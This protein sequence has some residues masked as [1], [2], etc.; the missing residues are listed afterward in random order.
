M[1]AA[2]SAWWY[3]QHGADGLTVAGTDGAD[4]FVGGEEAD[5]ISGLAGAD[6]LHGGDGDDLLIG[7][8]GDDWLLGGGGYDIYRYD[9]GDG[10]DILIDSDRLGHL[11][12]NG[13]QLTDAVR[14]LSRDGRPLWYNRELDVFLRFESGQ[15][16][17]PSGPVGTLIITGNGLGGPG[18]SI[19][20]RNFQMAVD[21]QGSLGISFSAA[22]QVAIIAGPQTVNPF[23]GADYV[24]QTDSAAL[25]EGSSAQLTLAVSDVADHARIIQLTASTDGVLSFVRDGVPVAL[26]TT[27]VGIEL[28]AGQM[29]LVLSVKVTGE[30]GAAVDTVLTA[31]LAGIGGDGG[32]VSTHALSLSFQGSVE[33]ATTNHVVGDGGSVIG[34][35][36]NDLIEAMV[37]EQGAAAR[38][39]NGS[40]GDDVIFALAEDDEQTLIDAGEL[41]ASVQQG[42]TY[43]AQIE[44]GNGNDRI[45]G[46]NGNDYVYAGA[47]ADLIVGGGGDDYILGDDALTT[48]EKARAGGDDDLIYGGAGND[49][50]F[51][52]RGDDVL[53]GG[54][55]DDRLRGGLGSDALFGGDGN[56]DLSGDSGETIWGQPSLAEVFLLHGDDFLD[57]G[58][59]DDLLSGGGGNDA[60]FGGD[61]NDVI[62]GG[63]REGPRLDPVTWN[64]FEMPSA[65]WDAQYP[66]DDDYLD[67]EGGDDWLYGGVGNDLLLGGE[68]ADVLYGD[69]P[70]A[71]LDHQGDDTLYGEDGDD[72][73]YGFGG[74]DLLD[75]GADDDRLYGGD[76]DDTLQGQGGND[77]LEGG[78][79]RDTLFGGDGNDQLI[80][81]TAAP[82]GPL[83]GAAGDA[84]VLDGGAGN[85]LLRGLGGDDRLLGG[86]GDDE[87][88]G[89]GGDDRLYGG[90]GNDLLYGDSPNLAAQHHGDDLL[91][92][93][94]GNDTLHGGG[95]N[96]ILQGGN[97]HDVLYGGA[98]DDR[99][100]GGD[101]ND[102][103]FGDDADGEEAG[104]DWLD[105]GDGD[106]HLYGGRGDDRLEGGAGNDVYHFAAGDGHDVVMEEAGTDTFVFGEGLSPA[107][108]QLSA[109]AIEFTK[110]DVRIDVATLFDPLTGTSAIEHFVFASEG[111]SLTFAELLA[112]KGL[113]IDAQGL[114]VGTPVNDNLRGGAGADFI[115]GGAGD[116]WLAGGAGNDLLFGGEGNDTYLFTEG[117]GVDLIQDGDGDNTIHLADG[118]AFQELS[119]TQE[120]GDVHIVRGADRMIIRDWDGNDTRQWSITWAG[121]L[122]DLFEHFNNGIPTVVD[123]AAYTS[124]DSFAA[125]SG[126]VLANDSDP[127]GEPL[128]V[129]NPGTYTGQYGTLQL[130]AD[131]AWQYTRNTAISLQ[132]LTTGES[133]TDSFT[134]TVSDGARSY[135]HKVS[136]VLDII[137]EGANDG[138]MKL[139]P[140]AQFAQQFRSMLPPVL[141]EERVYSVMLSAPPFFFDAEDGYLLAMTVT[142]ADG[143]TTPDWIHIE[144]P[145]EVQEIIQDNHGVQ[146]IPVVAYIMPDDSAVGTN[147]LR[148]YAMD[149]DGIRV[150]YSFTLNVINVNDWPIAHADTLHLQE[151]G[152]ASI[153]FQA[154]LANDTDEDIGDTLTVVS[155][156]PQS[157]QGM[158]LTVD[159][160][161]VTY[162]PAGA[163][164]FLAEGQ[165]AT[166]TFTY[167]ISDRSG[168][169][170]TGVVTVTITGQ[171]D[172]PVV[173][174]PQQAITVDDE[175]AFSFAFS[176]DVFADVDQGDVLDYT[177]TLTDGQPLPDWLS[178]DPVTLTISG[179]THKALAGSLSLLFTA[180]D[181]AGAS[182]SVDVALDVT[183]L[184]D[185]PTPAPDQF[186]VSEDAGAVTV[187]AA[188]LLAN[189]SDPDGDPL[190]VLAVDGLS[191][192]GA[193]VTLADG[194]VTWTAGRS[195]DYLAEGETVTDSFHYRV[196]DPAGRTA[197]AVVEVLVVGANDAPV[198]Q[199]DTIV[200]GEDAASVS[201]DATQLLGNDVD[202]DASD[203]LEISGMDPVSALGVTV[204]WS[205]G[206]ARYDGQGHFEYLGAGETVTDTFTYVVSDRAGSTASATVT[207]E[208]VGANDAPVVAAVLADRETD[209][210]EPFLFIVPAD[211]FT[212]VDA[213]DVLSL[214]AS[215]A[216]GSALPGWL[217]FDADSGTFS[218]VPPVG[219]GTLALR[220][221][222]TDLAGLSA[223]STFSLTVRD[224]LVLVGTDGQ[225]T[226]IGAGGDDILD[227]GAGVDVLIGGDGNDTYIVDAYA[228]AE[229]ADTGAGMWPGSAGSLTPADLRNPGA[230]LKNPGLGTPA[231]FVE[232]ETVV[233]TGDNGTDRVYASV[234]CALPDHV[235]ELVL[236]GDQAINGNGNALDNYLEGN[237]AAN[238]LYGNE[239]VD[240]LMGMGGNDLLVDSAGNGVLAGG[241]GSDLLLGNADRQL[242]AGGSGDD[243]ISTGGGIDVAL[244]N[245]G[246]GVDQVV[247]DA[248]SLT[249]S[250]GG[251]ISYQD[252]SL[253]RS[254]R[255]LVLG[256]GDGESVSLENWFG[257]D[258]LRPQVTLQVITAAMA[259]FDAGG[260]DH[261]ADQSAESFDFNAV[262]ASWEANRKATQWSLM[263]ALASTHLGGSDDAVIGGELAWHYGLTGSLSSANSPGA[264]LQLTSASFG[265]D[266]QF[267]EE[268][269]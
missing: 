142:L 132:R 99:L 236:T 89:D 164:D 160:G 34:T 116:D 120:D 166:D 183:N 56:D 259:G 266:R 251:G 267:I 129:I 93:G 169:Q 263:D 148:L 140:D 22:P 81:D 13:T 128:H 216:D 91:D 35:A 92:G 74:D 96:D 131:G 138:P 59:G 117:G 154:L 159:Q 84:D 246:D 207:V 95:G 153:T 44:G 72:F 32:V 187:A 156:S 10:R 252:L 144:P 185:T 73:L 171:N 181:A 108:L 225:D 7:G 18:N 196:G 24:P 258:A 78:A 113:D 29:L 179:H 180:T 188:T 79:G 77:Y 63:S 80:G 253:S 241:A 202:P 235:E 17:G 222:A 54:A 127:T 178:F 83:D 175:E 247:S 220:V 42:T 201:I 11:E 232:T 46:S 174:M 163:Y 103:L 36:A 224:G 158:A 118:I 85:D 204:T 161:V 33:S 221:T 146:P 123:D 107:G 186:L 41:A 248:G 197:E 28:P 262:A 2:G 88:H 98:G 47:G 101:G 250:L 97:D 194:Q 87:L 40:D 226:L 104:H 203:S 3:V 238:A 219:A 60:L 66:T 109:G 21:G 110:A 90:A 121:G 26:G 64:Y 105:G 45:F 20:I 86:D 16:V 111:I 192:G 69:Y 23:Y 189:D 231:G 134:Y 167:R 49:F 261:L 135:T 217:S 43:Y 27:P 218:G 12:I 31:T 100:Y 71:A 122:V 190:S 200:A 209:A 15:G 62:R 112:L 82:F 57:G 177:L 61:G 212:D 244:F 147:F 30:L 240:V 65:Q 76:G 136:G 184:N 139:Y 237:E 58:A 25:T 50:L 268:T 208:I 264:R 249:L 75:G 145:I 137:I 143:V 68:G 157:A 228:G 9:A 124:E 256:V 51:G 8:T 269:G 133:V 141:T 213:T 102:Q 125:L 193:T 170:S 114:G 38:F 162:D 52:E 70:D 210:D 19:E 195:F 39:I 4:V 1:Q 211:T 149:S 165:T 242:L 198:A 173:V 245:R 126:N 234:S 53:H 214:S 199:A 106:D 182:A 94:D 152:V 37:F 176:P 243:V 150:Y 227:G 205:D 67:G 254:G 172:A 230:L 223:G 233:E 6:L 115:I 191:S 168:A 260:N 55:G 14:A 257:R 255:D 119:V 215:M 239:G 265:V 206:A 155:V 130:A 151:D 5:F 48:I 229:P